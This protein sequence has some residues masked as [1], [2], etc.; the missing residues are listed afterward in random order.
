MVEMVRTQAAFQVYQVVDAGL[1][2]LIM[3]GDLGFGGAQLLMAPRPGLESS[4][5]LPTR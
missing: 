5:L 3:Q 1:E 2:A 4:G